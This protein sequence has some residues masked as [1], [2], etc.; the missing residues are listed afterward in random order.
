MILNSKRRLSSAQGRHF[1]NDLFSLIITDANW[2]LSTMSFEG[3]EEGFT[4]DPTLFYG[5]T[6]EEDNFPGT[7]DD[8]SPYVGENARDPLHRRIV[9]RTLT[10]GPLSVAEF[11]VKW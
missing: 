7:G 2:L 1:P 9:D 4:K 10:R 5:S 3:T 11:R 8:H 6:H